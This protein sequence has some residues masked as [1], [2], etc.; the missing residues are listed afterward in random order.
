MSGGVPVRNYGSY[1][2]LTEDGLTQWHPAFLALA[3]TLE[4]CAAAYRRFCERYVA[5]EKRQKKGRWGSK[6]LKKIVARGKPKK[7]VS[8]GQQLIW[9]DWDAPV[10]E[11]K[12]VAEKFVKANESPLRPK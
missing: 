5:K 11:I 12:L 6:L 1:E 4:L 9:Q 8:P 2:R 3:A 10:E 7:K